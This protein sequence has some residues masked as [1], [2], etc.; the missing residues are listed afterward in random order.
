M[1]R[2]EEIKYANPFMLIFGIIVFAVALAFIVFVYIY[3]AIVHAF[4][5]AW[6]A[7]VKTESIPVVMGKWN[8][9]LKQLLWRKRN[10]E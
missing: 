7:T 4:H 9:F 3:I 8:K 1:K 6:A 5:I 2:D 10:E